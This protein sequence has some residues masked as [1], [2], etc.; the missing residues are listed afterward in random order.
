MPE[1][2]QSLVVNFEIWLLLLRLL[3]DISFL[4]HWVLMAVCGL[5]H[6]CCIR[7]I[8]FLILLLVISLVDD[9][10]WV[11]FISH[12][13]QLGLLLSAIPRDPLFQAVHISQILLDLLSQL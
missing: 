12:A 2:F 7:V 10:L 9:V 5:A 4:G 1:K 13:E 3:V 11:I 6:G 8:V